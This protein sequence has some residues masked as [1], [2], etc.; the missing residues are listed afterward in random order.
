MIQVRQLLMLHF[1]SPHIV[2]ILKQMVFWNFSG[3]PAGLHT[4]NFLNVEYNVCTKKS[5]A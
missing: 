3:N 1:L 4:I 2:T 5:I